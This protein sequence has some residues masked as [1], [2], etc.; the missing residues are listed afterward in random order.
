MGCTYYPC[1]RDLES[2]EKAVLSQL[3]I[4]GGKER[5]PADKEGDGSRESSGK[6][7]M[8]D[9]GKMVTCGGEFSQTRVEG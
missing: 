6:L 2:I 8:A 3:G 7:G 1:T 4:T 5:A 9:K